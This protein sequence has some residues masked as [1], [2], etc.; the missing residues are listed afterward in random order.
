MT[1]N[2]I[3]KSNDV[4]DVIIP[5]EFMQWPSDLP[6]CMQPINSSYTIYYFDR[7]RVAPLSIQDYSYS[8]LPKCFG[9]LDTTAL[10]ESGI[11][12]LQTQPALSLRGSG[13]LM[14]FIDTGIVYENACF[15]NSDGSS[16]IQ[17][18]WDQT[19]TPAEEGEE[20]RPPGGFLYGVEYS[21][22][23][24]NNALASDDPRSLVPTTDTVGHGTALASIACGSADPAS[25]FTGAAPL[26]DIL[27]VKLKPAKQYLKDF[28]F[29]PEDT[30]CYQEN[31]IMAGV[32]YLE[33]KAREYGQPIIICLG[34]GT[35]N[36]SHSGG[37][38]L[39]EYLNDVGGH[40]RRCIVTASGN[41]ALARHHFRGPDSPMGPEGVE[42]EIN[43][44]ENM[45]G[46]YLE[47]WNT[48]P[49]LFAVS[50]RS[51][52]GALLPAVPT[53][54]TGHQEYLFR[55][56]NT[57]IIVDYRTVGR[58]RGDQLVFIRLT[59]VPRG[60][61]TLRVSP[62]AAI[63]G[64]FHVWLPMTGMLEH[65]VFFLRPDP[66]VTLTIPGSASIPITVG[67]YNPGGG[68]LYLSSGRGFTVT[69][70]IKPDF[71]APAVNV[72][73]VDIRGNYTAIT[74]TSAAAA[75]TAGACAQIMEWGEIRRNDLSLNSVEIGNILI[76]GCTRDRDRIYP[77]TQWGYGKLDVYQAFLLL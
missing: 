11:L 22:A 66:D 63:T 4:V 18:I 39:S 19:A 37:S 52:S 73:A 27:V 17:G 29:I 26:A 69:N 65:D 23:A 44:E 50:L 46:F 56:E 42:V 12:Q 20:N 77:N 68:S 33:G 70:N 61:W 32:A 7:S 9:L 43:V 1:C 8:Y 30:L 40:W 49:D 25:N 21:Q 38:I 74:G 15:R 54:T 62:E 57:Q 2:E 3:I 53:R 75:V 48:A 5:V 45:N 41:E 64:D 51:P 58:T 55:L 59:N 47:L 10:E 72:Q 28:F 67:G 31:D 60:V 34:L 24:L 71:V 13:V 16:R 35:N 6:D 14:G 76:R 36:G